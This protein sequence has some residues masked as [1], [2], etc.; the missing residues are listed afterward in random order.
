MFN[1]NDDSILELF[2]DLY[3]D[4]TARSMVAILHLGCTYGAKATDEAQKQLDEFFTEYGNYD[5]YT[6]TDTGDVVGGEKHE[7]EQLELSYI[8]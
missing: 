2:A 6:Y 7:L 3:G 1:V 8:Q 5:Y 4:S